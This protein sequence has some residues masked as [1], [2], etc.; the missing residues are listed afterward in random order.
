MFIVGLLFTNTTFRESY[1][2]LRSG[3]DYRTLLRLLEG[4]SPS[5]WTSD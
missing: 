2:L 3:V 1:L 5:Y 4:T